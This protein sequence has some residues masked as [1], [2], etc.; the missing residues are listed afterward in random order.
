MDYS[1]TNT[2]LGTQGYKQVNMLLNTADD[3]ELW[4]G[5]RQ[6]V[7][8]SKGIWKFVNPESTDDFNKLYPEVAL[9]FIGDYALKEKE[10]RYRAK[11]AQAQAKPGSQA[12]TSTV[13]EDTLFGHQHLTIDELALYQAAQK[14]AK[15]SKEV[16]SV[17]E[18]SLSSF[19]TDILTTVS[20]NNLR[21]IINKP[22]PQEKLAT[23][24][25]RYYRGNV[26]APDQLGAQ[27]RRLEETPKA[28][29]P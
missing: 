8:I 16:R 13:A 15:E 3:W 25:A 22:T 23:L 4:M 2:E 20:R 19:S 9:P 12:S 18:R 17:L 24:K 21:M 6:Q 29:K 7:A 10:K 14:D 5:L 1:N 27:I 11:E 26:S 28:C